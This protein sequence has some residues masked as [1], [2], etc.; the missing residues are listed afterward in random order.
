[1]S[2]IQN[3]VIML[4]SEFQNIVKMTVEPKEFEAV[5]T[6]YMN[7]DLNKYEFCALWIKMNQ[8]RVNKAKEEAKANAKAEALRDKLW[9]IIAKFGD[10]DWSWKERTFASTALNKREEKAI[11]EAGLKLM[12]Y[13]HYEQRNVYKRMSTILWD[14]RKY[15]KAA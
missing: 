7:S 10:K 4:Q 9:N 14:I 3:L 5:N 6:V 1:M 12:E 15:L 11:E 2:N 8:S 13:N